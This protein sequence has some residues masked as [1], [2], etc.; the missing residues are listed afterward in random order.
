M[1]K[2]MLFVIALTSMA[3]FSQ[4]ARVQV[5]HNC[6]DAAAAEV[7]VYLNGTILLNDF[8]FRTATPFVDAPAGTPIT[9]VV[10]PGNST[11][12]ADGIYTLTTTL[13]ANETYILVANGIVS[14]TGYTPAQAFQLSVFAG[15]RETADSATAVDMLVN[16]GST[17]APAVDVV[18]TSV[19]VG[20]VINDIAYPSFSPAYLELMPGD[21]TIDITTADGTTVVASYLAPL[22]T[23]GL[24][25]QA[26]TV[27]ASG[28]LNP[29]NNSNGPA[30]GLWAATAAGGDLI[31]LP[32]ANQM[33]R[34]QVIHNAADLAAQ[35][36]DVYLNGDM[37]I[38]DFEFRTASPFIDAPAGVELEI[39]VAPGNSTSA[40]DGI[41][42]LEAT[43]AADET[44]VI[45]ANGIV[46]ATGYTPNQAFD[47]YIYPMG[48]EM[49]SN[50]ENVDVLVF[51]GSTDAPT[52]DAVEPG[53]GLIVNDISY[54][55]FD[56]YLELVPD[57]YILNVTTADG[58]TVVAGYGAP[59]ETLGLQGQAITVLASGFLDPSNNSNGPGFGLWVALPG[60]GD[61]V[62]LPAAT[63]NT[64]SFSRANI[65]VYPNPA[66]TDINISI[67]AGFTSLATSIYDMAGREVLKAEGSNINVSGLTSGIYLLSST[68]DGKSYQQRIVINN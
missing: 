23:L 3:G 24:E 42:T 62:E 13:T 12:A 60:G 29:E 25:G 38:D 63:A 34:V 27:L 40:A 66:N 47:L 22:E 33:A 18:E 37:L 53:V 64:A 4:T 14:A 52:V 1:R 32:L 46:S 59:L 41:Y 68:I 31:A 16:H 9:I 10:A 65:A 51:H 11:S 48:R 39:V 35:T 20:T 8:A 17:D 45:I 56:G 61:L 54:G 15:A 55:E 58:N 36:V 21:Y 19:P 26:I 50:P 57:D 67:P 44:Y 28:F 7:D 2:I 43:L 6:A 5:I 30:F 49:A